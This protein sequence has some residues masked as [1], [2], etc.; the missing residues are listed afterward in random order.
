[1]KYKKLL[2]IIFCGITMLYVWKN[3]FSKVFI[4]ENHRNNKKYT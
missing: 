4:P 3:C 1:M 2:I